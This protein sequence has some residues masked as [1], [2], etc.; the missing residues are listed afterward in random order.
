M[1]REYSPPESSD[2]TFSCCPL[3][4]HLEVEGG[5]RRSIFLLLLLLADTVLWISQT[6]TSSSSNRLLIALN[7]DSVFACCW[8]RNRISGDGVKAAPSATWSRTSLVVVVVG[9][10]GES[11]DT[12]V[13]IDVIVLVVGAC[14]PSPR[15]ADESGGAGLR[16]SA[17]SSC[18]CAS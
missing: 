6:L 16:P 5:L 8:T 2:R 11:G 12:I 7:V 14:F 3:A 18:S 1:V 10:V 15:A 17:P 9:A 4:E 13:A